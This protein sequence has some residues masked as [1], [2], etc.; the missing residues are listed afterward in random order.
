VGSGTLLELQDARLGLLQAKL[1]LN[2]SVYTY[3]TLKSSLDKLLG[4]N[5]VMNK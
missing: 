5:Q 1:N 3:M 4:V 2:Q